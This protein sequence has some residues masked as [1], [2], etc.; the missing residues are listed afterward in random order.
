MQNVIQSLSI[1]KN[2]FVVVDC[3]ELRRAVKNLF[4][5]DVTSFMQTYTDKQAEAVAFYLNKPIQ[6]VTKIKL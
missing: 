1:G 3:L 2:K 5:L 4:S 6:K